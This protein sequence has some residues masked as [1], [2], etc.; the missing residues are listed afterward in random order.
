MTQITGN[1][2]GGDYTSAGKASRE[3]KEALKRIGAS[4]TAMRKAMVATY[5]AEMNVVIHAHGGNISAA[6][7]PEALEVIVSDTGPGI[8]DI[9]R[10]MQEG[11]STAPQEA[12]ELGFGAGM[13]LPNI[14]RNTDRF[15]IQS[16]LDKG[17]KLQF[18][19]FLTPQQG[20]E[21]YTAAVRISPEKCKSCLR[22]LHVCPTQ[23]I[24]VRNS[25][26]FI[27]PHLCI[28]CTACQ[29]ACPEQVY[30]MDC[31]DEP[32]EPTENTVLFL[33]APLRGQFGGPVSNDALKA[34]LAS[35]GW[36][37]VWMSDPWERALADA[38]KRMADEKS[39]PGPLLPPVCPAIINLIQ[40]RYPSML[41]NIAPF[42]SAL[43]AAREFLQAG[44]KIFVVPCAALCSLA[45]ESSVMHSCTAV[46]PAWLIRS[47]TPMINEHAQ[48]QG[49]C[50]GT[51]DAP[52]VTITG[53]DRV[54]Q[55]LDEA[56][57]GRVNDC[58]IVNLY[59]CD[60]GCFGSPVWPEHPEVS[61]YRSQ[62]AADFREL[63]ASAIYRPKPLQARA[64]LRLDNDMGK[65]ILKLTKI[66]NLRK[67][68]PGRDCGVC[69]SPTCLALAEDIVLGRADV[70]ACVYRVKH[71]AADQTS[72]DEENI[73]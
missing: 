19:I 40:V 59:A 50:V 3:I 52:T 46:S 5:E 70:E 13:G 72:P 48:T 2:R 33:P 41:R 7:S 9:T 15:S 11:Y 17:T 69:G 61:R 12:R 58:G 16:E 37:T 68:L 51:Q 6:V 26:P 56:E 67:I 30:S 18:T 55:F 38:V 36:N 42:L 8:P 4:T 71:G 57:D 65:A 27:V 10:A 47:L 21:V 1:I 31:P 64:G 45:R 25:A 62:A 49:C 32:P 20:T 28:G 22:C 14:K 66:D 60:S 44:N 53:I 73:V 43:E 34:A 29:K 35:L 54:C 23:A 39:S 63:E 24:R